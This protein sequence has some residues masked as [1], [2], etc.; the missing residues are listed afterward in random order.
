VTAAA[1]AATFAIV[2]SMLPLAAPVAAQGTWTL[3]LGSPS[4]VTTTGFVANGTVTSDGNAGFVVVLVVPTGTPLTT[5][6][7][8][9][10]LVIYGVAE[11]GTQ[12]TSIPVDQ[13]MP[14]TSYTYELLAIEDDNAAT[15]TSVAGTI[16]TSALPTS[17]GTP[18]IPPGHPPSVGIFGLC[19]SDSDQ[20]C[21]NDMNGV[22]AA[23]ENLAPLSLP[24]NWA[25]LT[26]PE[27]M[28][29]WANLERTSRGEAAIP[30]LVNTYDAAVETGLA[31]DA[32]PSLSNLPGEAASISAGAYPNVASAMYAW[33]YDDGFG[34]AS[35]ECTV[36]DAPGCWGH[37]D[38]I[39][40]DAATLGSN[41][42]EMDAGDGIDASGS[43]E[44]DVLLVADPTPTA[45]ANIVLTW[46]QEQPFLLSPPTGAVIASGATLPSGQSIVSPNAQYGQFTLSMQ[47]DGNLVEYNS[48]GF[49]V[50]FSGTAGNAGAYAQMQ[51]D[52]N[53]VV[54]S[55][56]GSPV[57][58]SNTVGNPGAYLELAPDGALVVHSPTVTPLWSGNSI[59][60]ERAQL[61]DGLFL[62]STSNGYTLIMQNDGNLVEYDSA[63]VAVW[64]SGTSGNAGAY[65]V[66]QGDGNLVIYNTAGGPLW[67]SNTVGNPGAYLELGPDGA[68]IVHGPSGT[69]LWSGIS[70]LV[71]NTELAS[72]SSL[73]SPSGGY[74]LTM[75]ADGNLVE[76]TSS[77]APIWASGT[78]GNAGAYVVMQ[79]DGNLVVYN[80][81][82]SPLWDSKTVG[83]PGAYLEVG[84]DGA[85]IVHG[86][87]GTPLWSGNSVAVENTQPAGGFSLSSPGGGYTLNMQPD[88]DLVE[89]NSAGV[90]VWSSGTS[91]NHGAF[92]VMQGDGNL[93][94]YSAADAPLW[95]S[96]TAGNPGAYL[97]L[98]PS[99]NLDVYSP[100]AVILW[101]T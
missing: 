31:D 96:D 32:D 78:S 16:T 79:G 8:T 90:A 20:G 55:I 38:T 47:T 72:G 40:A 77:D 52:G 87:Y 60:V 44:Y 3:A 57:W 30:N 100:S 76:T 19:S 71:Q 91:G 48:S 92:A 85:L 80:T 27:Q 82:S 24:F 70:L 39:L 37:R 73:S 66:M 86:P 5:S 98:E 23:Q 56:A 53:L 97:E 17:P 59:L 10:G 18:I 13:L 42:T 12:T 14:D 94:V 9:A 62:S 46:A 74:T 2:L 65:V 41:P 1:I 45:P 68:L 43:V 67:A 61:T 6:S 54:Y 84:P 4:G 83:N 51:G 35:G 58:A 22:R 95:A 75:Q 63:N 11:T 50:W 64:S 28:F 101:T 25:T 89:T 93:V 15:F 26:G 81:A 21:V 29:V 88:G 99:G 7:P 33:L 36:P 49:A 69:P 34:G